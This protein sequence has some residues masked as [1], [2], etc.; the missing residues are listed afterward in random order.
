MTDSRAGGNAPIW[1]RILAALGLAWNLYGVYQYFD[2]V[3]IVGAGGA[4]AA[5]SGA[6]PLWVTVAFA[7]AVLAGSLGSLC[8]L[9]LSR[10]ATPLL[11][12]SLLAEL[13]WDVPMV[14]GGDGSPVGIAAMVS[15]VG[16][17]LAWVAYSAGKKGWLR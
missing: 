10:W 4:Q 8:L 12:L 11:I 5:L 7:I 13:A 16:V 9:L 14:G 6:V 17:L 2:T 3:G 1:L 15:V